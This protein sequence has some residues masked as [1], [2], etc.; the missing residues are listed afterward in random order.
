MFV[1]LLYLTA[2]EPINKNDVLTELNKIRIILYKIVFGKIESFNSSSSSDKASGIKTRKN[3]KNP[4]LN[5]KTKNKT[6]NKKVTTN[7]SFKRRPK[8]KRF[9]NPIFLNFK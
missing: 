9:K 2:D 3:K 1:K 6:K 5:I 8:V 7:I 4:F